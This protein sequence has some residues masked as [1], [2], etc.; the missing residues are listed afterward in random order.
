VTI[1]S[2]AIL[3]GGL[4]TRMRPLTEKIPKALLEVAGKPFIHHQLMLLKNS[5]LERVVMCVGFLGEMLRDEVGDGSAFGLQVDYAFDGDQLLGTGGAL[6]R[7]LPL[8]GESF[9]VTYGDAYLE[10]DY[11]AIA[12]TFSKSG[13]QGLMVVYHNKGQWD[14]SNVIYANHEILRY[15][16]VNHSNAMEYIDYGVGMLRASVF[17]SYPEGEKFDLATVYGALVQSH[18]MAG[19]ET[20]KRFYEIGSKAGLQETHAYLNMR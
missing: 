13:K 15:D 17:D 2:I 1:P 8:L 6:K 10:T 18:Q 12:H 19:Y 5:G 9:F 7:A 20:T 3:A 11:R 16:K 4:A 14:T